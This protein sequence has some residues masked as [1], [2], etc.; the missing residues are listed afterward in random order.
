VGLFT[1]FQ[2]SIPIII[3]LEMAIRAIFILLLID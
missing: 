3:R 2:A 1:N